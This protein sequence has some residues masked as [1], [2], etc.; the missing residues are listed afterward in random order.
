MANKSEWQKAVRRMANRLSTDARN[1]LVLANPWQ[2]TAHS[3][4]QAWRNRASQEQLQKPT[5]I[6]RRRVPVTWEEASRLMM[7]SL[8]TRAKAHAARSTWP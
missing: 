4:V 6:V 5:R 1:H 8:A 3:M 2:R 7:V